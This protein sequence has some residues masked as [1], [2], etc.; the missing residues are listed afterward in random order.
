[1]IIRITEPSVVVLVGSSGSGKSTFART[2]F[3]ATEVLS[4]DFFR[5]LV[6]DDEGSLTASEAAFDALYYVARKRLEAHKLVVIDATNVDAAARGVALQLARELHVLAVAIVLNLSAEVCLERNAT[7]PDRQFGGHVVRR[8]VG[9]VRR[10]IRSLKNEGFRQFYV[11]NTPEEVAGVTVERSKLWNDKK[12]DHGPFDIIGDVHGCREELVQLLTQLGWT[13]EGTREAPEVT[14]PPGRRAIFL[15]DLVDRGPDSPGALYLAMHMHQRG[16]ALV[17][18]GNHEVKLK[19]KLDGRDVKLSHGLEQTMEQLAREPPE[20][21]P[22]ISKWIDGLVSHYVLD[23]GKLVVAHAGLSAE[24]Q[25]RA[26]ARVREFALYGDTTGETDE[27]GLPVRYPWAREYRGRASVVYGHTPVPE[28]DWLNGTICIDTGCVFGGKL[29]A[30][31]WPEKV[32]VEVPAARTYYEPVRPLELAVTEARAKQDTALDID[33]VR[34]KRYIETRYGPAVTVRPENAA[35]ALEVMARFAVDPRWL[36]YL[37][38]TMSPARAAPPGSPL[39][40]SPEMALDYF[41]TEGVN[42]VVCQEKH[43]GSRAV[44]VLAKDERAAA[45]RFGIEGEGQGVIYTR[46]GRPFFDDEALEAEL[47]RRTAAALDAAGVWRELDSDWVVIDAELLPWS[48]KAQA[49][50]RGQY[51]AVGAAGRASLAAARSSLEAVVARLPPSAAVDDGRSRSSSSKVADAQALL[52][53]FQARERAVE[54]YVDAYRRYCW[55]VSSVDDLVIAPFHLLASEGAVHDAREHVWHMDM[56]RRLADVAPKTFRATPYRVVDLSD[57]A[58][59]GAASDW[60]H[61]LVARGGEGMVVKP[62][63]YLAR[64]AHGLVQ[65]AIKCR[66]PEYLRIIYGPEYL[67]PS[68]LERLRGRALGHKRALALRELALGLEALHRF[69]SH[70][71]LSRVHECVF[72]VLA[73][74][75][76]PVDPRL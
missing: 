71:G 16:L 74:E 72:G 11:L 27:Y 21:L 44:L 64:G 24:L 23:D 75:S 69:V 9:A 60:W 49:L 53:R 26:S 76:E 8:H 45:R 67:E 36:V 57:S 3:K 47:L 70:A 6:C 62:K 39:L 63:S 25:G 19:K 33:D 46:T 59:R 65:P 68:A 1:M 5:G 42:E 12:D 38:P 4:S 34:G 28:A 20:R 29:T 58:A 35:A 14:P 10:S 30:L 73:L 55:P 18:P 48:A 54:R 2:H 15:G 66:G 40:E 61:E 52:A 17:I 41:A 7:R 22:Q 56:L 13:I 37:P 50:L 32:L 51:A 43:M 31:R